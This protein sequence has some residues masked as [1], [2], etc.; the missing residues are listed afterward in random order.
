[1]FASHHAKAETTE[2]ILVL[3]LNQVI[4]KTLNFRGHLLTH[5]GVVVV[6]NDNGLAGLGHV[7]SSLFVF[8]V[9]I[10]LGLRWE[11]N[12]ARLAKRS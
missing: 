1:M 7:N 12:K 10:L 8:G 9:I 11:E 3:H 6:T 5:V 2:K 4:S